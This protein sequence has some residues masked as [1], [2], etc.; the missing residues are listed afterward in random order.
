MSNQPMLDKGIIV[1]PDMAEEFLFH[2]AIT[3]F[4]SAVRDADGWIE[5]WINGSGGSTTYETAICDLIAHH[6]KVKGVLFGE[7]DSANGIVW[8]TCQRRYVQP[9]SIL[10]VHC[11]QYRGRKNVAY[12]HADFVASVNSSGFWNKRGAVKFAAISNKTVGFWLDLMAI[13]GNDLSFIPAH[14]IVHI[15]QMAEWYHGQSPATE[16][17]TD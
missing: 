2:E 11:T 4:Q 5:M 6:G 10:G 12:T 13:A 8:A 15:H 7:A 17:S 9:N 1:C 16:T 3:A 14:D